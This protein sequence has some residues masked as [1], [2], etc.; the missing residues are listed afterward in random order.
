MKG[1]SQPMIAILTT[2]VA[3]AVLISFALAKEI[4]ARRALQDMMHRLIFYRGATHDKN[5]HDAADSDRDADNADH[6]VRMPE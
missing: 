2:T 5:L 3:L 6:V 4:R 1:T